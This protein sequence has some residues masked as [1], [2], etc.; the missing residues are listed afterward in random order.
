MKLHTIM[1]AGLACFSAMLLASSATG[2]DLRNVK[3]GD[4]LPAYHLPTIAGEEVQSETSRGKVVVLV[5]LSA[6][7]RSSEL[8]AMESQ[9]VVR[10]FGDENV[11]LL[12]VTADAIYKQYFERFRKEHGI[13]A[14][15]AFDASRELYRELGLIVF[16]TTVIV[17]R[18]GCLSHV[19]ATRGIDYA[20][21]LGSYVRHTLGMINDEELATR[22]ESQPSDP[23]S[24]RSRA[25][26][27]R[28][29]ARLLRE[30][31]L[32]DSALK[33]LESALTLDPENVDVQLDLADLR[34]MTAEYEEAERLIDTI[35]AAHPTHR[36]ARLLHGIVLFR[37]DRLEEAET[38]LREV[39][40]LN[41]DPGRTHYYLGRIYEAQEREAEALRHYRAALSRVLNEPE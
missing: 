15:L 20:H 27:H 32:F 30:K 25:A 7:Q 6:E 33:E 24:S 28:A 14:A 3:V 2:R 12:H 41:P 1:T 26:R 4:E 13:E 38:T 37:T 34:L 8:A 21:A 11:A 19:I 16:P 18:E 31:N 17:D 23:R 40:T 35:L 39:L 5:Y 29:A 22:L 36:R 9:A 10:E